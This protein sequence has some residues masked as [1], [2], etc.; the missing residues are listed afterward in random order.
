MVNAVCNGTLGVSGATTLASTL[1]CTGTATFNGDVTVFV[2]VNAMGIY[3]VS[4]R[5]SGTTVLSSG[6]AAAT[7]S[8][9]RVSGQAAGVWRI[10][11]PT[12]PSGTANYNI[13]VTGYGVAAYVRTAYPNTSTYFDVTTYTIGTSTIIDG[14]YSFQVMN[15]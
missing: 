6:G 11:F 10:T 4:G 1:T 14:Q 15:W 8:V 5:V 9:A 7:W 12:H 2:T 13:I 3:W